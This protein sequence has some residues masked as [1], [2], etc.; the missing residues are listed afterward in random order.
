M[1]RAADEDEPGVGRPCVLHGHHLWARGSY[2]CLCSIHAPLEFAQLPSVPSL[3]HAVVL[4][5]CSFMMEKKQL[6][7][8]TA[9]WMAAVIKK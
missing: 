6:G 2:V 9:H 8:K 7:M 4:W 5:F 3:R 1:E